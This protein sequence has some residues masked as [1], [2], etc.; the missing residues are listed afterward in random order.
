MSVL[1]SMVL[2]P[3]YECRIRI[4]HPMFGYTSTAIVVALGISSCSNSSLFEPREPVRKL[5]PVTLPPGRLRLATRPSLTG[6]LPVANT[7]GTVMVV[8]FAASA[9]MELATIHRHWKANQI[10][11]ESVESV[12]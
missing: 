12:F 11:G 10:G 6:S 5:T 7:I 3:V 2:A 4:E 8:A 1:A 9:A